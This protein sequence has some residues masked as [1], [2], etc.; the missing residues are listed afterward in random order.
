MIKWHLEK[1][2]IKDLIPHPKNPRRLS[3][4]QAYHLQTS[5][6][7]FG[8]ADKPIINSNNIIIGGHQRLQI[9]KKMGE[10]EIDCWVP[11]H[12]LSHSEIDEMNI[13]LNKNLGEWD[14]DILA[15]EWD[16][17]ELVN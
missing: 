8:I 2:K 5:L 10:K 1:R 11:D 14:W 12:Q 9:L 15:N 17:A 16:V 3:K 13:R 4:D 6:E 7:K